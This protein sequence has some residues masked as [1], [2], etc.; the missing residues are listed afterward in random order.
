VN[1]SNTAMTLFTS[2]TT[3]THKDLKAGSYTYQVEDAK[4]CKIQLTAQIEQNPELK[5]IVGADTTLSLGD[6][7]LLVADIIGLIQK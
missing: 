6:S 7:I 4:Q 5:V 3:F 1:G 2:N